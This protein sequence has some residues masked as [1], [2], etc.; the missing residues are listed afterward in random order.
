MFR[1]FSRNTKTI[2]IK[3]ANQPPIIPPPI[4]NNLHGEK[5]F[6]IIGL[7]G[8]L[9]NLILAVGTFLLYNEATKQS[10][11][12]QQS[13]DAAA[14]A[15]RQAQQ[16]NTL[17]TNNYNLAKEVFERS[18]KSSKETFKLSQRSVRAQIQSINESQL[19]FNIANE[20]VLTVTNISPQ[21]LEIGKSPVIKYDITN[22]K[23]VPVKIISEQSI[24]SITFNPTRLEYIKTILAKR[25]KENGLHSINSYVVK[26]TPLAKISV[27]PDHLDTLNLNLIVK[28]GYCF[29]LYGFV[30]YKNLANGRIRNYWYVLR[31]KSLQ[32]RGVL[33][34]FLCNEN[35]DEKEKVKLSY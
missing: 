6:D 23:E 4:I 29:Y 25:E 27:S 14:E 5:P 18:E 2:H 7:L 9:I 24:S 26:G 22:L 12:S 15:A 32:N 11:I 16:S 1:R 28:S 19:Q 33:I 3:V 35:F 13:A 34:D 30:K 17:S 10:R 20:P 21:P 31:L 8:I